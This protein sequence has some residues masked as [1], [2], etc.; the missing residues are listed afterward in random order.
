MGGG[1]VEV[2]GRCRK[3]GK[4]TACASVTSG[5]SSRNTESNAWRFLLTKNWTVAHDLLGQGM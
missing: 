2:Q 4:G 5:A 1:R 3:R